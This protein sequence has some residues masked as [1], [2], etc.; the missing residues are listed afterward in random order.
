MTPGQIETER[1]IAIDSIAIRRTHS[2][3]PGNSTLFVGHLALALN[4]HSVQDFGAKYEGAIDELFRELGI[5]RTRRVY[6]A[7]E[8]AKTLFGRPRVYD[9]FL[10]RFA[11]KILA[12][13]GLKLTAFIGSFDSATLE[14][15]PASEVVPESFGPGEEH[16]I[17]ARVPV[18]GRNPGRTYVSLLKFL[19]LIQNPF[20]ALAAWKLCER[21]GAYNQTFLLDYF[22]GHLSQAWDELIGR[23]RVSLVP[24]GDTC[25]PY[26]S[27]ADLLLRG[28]DRQLVRNNVRTER[29]TVRSALIQ[30][31]GWEPTAEVHVHIISNP[32][33]PMIA[34]YSN[35]PIVGDA[36]VRHPI[37]L[38]YNENTHGLERAEIE[39]SPL[40]RSVADRAYDL[41]GSVMFYRPDKSSTLIRDGDWLVHYGPKGAETFGRLRRLGYR[42]N[43]WRA[44]G[45][46]SETGPPPP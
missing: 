1:T 24:D 30:M 31:G 37:I 27:A 22:E 41:R 26:I 13:D 25:S 29:H 9:A 45:E 8:I 43:E 44:S 23:N 5:E 3:S 35:S 20:P 32:E 19:G 4:L 11:R 6:D 2:D 28:L 42:L 46:G 10:F 18:Y 36:F 21:T 38:I 12:I 40:M 17:R 14:Q 16:L 34:P 7:H 33:I 39:N 15:L